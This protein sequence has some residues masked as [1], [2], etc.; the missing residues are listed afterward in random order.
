MKQIIMMLSLTFYSLVSSASGWVGEST[1]ENYYVNG[2]GNLHIRLASGDVP[3]GI[4]SCANRT[5]VYYAKTDSNYME[6]FASV[7]AATA[8]GSTMNFFVAGCKGG[9]ND[10]TYPHGRGF[11]AF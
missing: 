5:Y 6:V 1:I 7:M 10:N 9:S 8:N 4:Q 3:S 11:S 2:S